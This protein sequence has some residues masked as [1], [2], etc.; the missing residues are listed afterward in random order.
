M[1]IRQRLGEVARKH[2]THTY[3]PTCSA[4]LGTYLGSDSVVRAPTCVHGIG[5]YACW[6]VQEKHTHRQS[7]PDSDSDLASHLNTHTHLVIH[8]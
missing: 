7:H 4:S 2:V 8:V 6:G 3:S 5:D 1:G